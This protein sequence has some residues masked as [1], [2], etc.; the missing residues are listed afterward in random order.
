MLPEKL[1]DSLLGLMYSND[2]VHV[3]NIPYNS[4]NAWKIK[5]SHTTVTMPIKQGQKG[6]IGKITVQGISDGADKS[7][8]TIS[9]NAADAHIHCMVHGCNNICPTLIAA[10]CRSTML[11]IILICIKLSPMPMSQIRNHLPEIKV[12]T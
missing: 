3:P 7:L 10:T 2:D 1:R 12:P 5:G 8:A 6:K 11:R 4:I 9:V